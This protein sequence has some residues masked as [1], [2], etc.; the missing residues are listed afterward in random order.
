[1]L[2]QTGFL[3]IAPTLIS[4][5]VSSSSY[6]IVKHYNPNF[7]MELSNEPLFPSWTNSSKETSAGAGTETGASNESFVSTA[8]TIRGLLHGIPNAER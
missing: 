2:S 7:L 8:K 3:R 6:A 4:T 5:L 1:M